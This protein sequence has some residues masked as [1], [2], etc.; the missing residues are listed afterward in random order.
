[1]HNGYKL[2]ENKRDSEDVCVVEEVIYNY[3]KFKPML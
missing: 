3:R 2:S 1:M